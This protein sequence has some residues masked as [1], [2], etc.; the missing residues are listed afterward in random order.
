MT[1][2]H[3]HA[4]GRI[5]IG[6]VAVLL[7]VGCGAEPASGPTST[8]RD[9]AGVTIVENRGAVALDGGGW[10]LAA[11]P[12]VTIGSVDGPEEAQLYRVRGALRL[13]DGRIAV[14]NDGS[15]E[16]RMFGADGTHVRSWGRE[17]EGPG[18]FSSMI[19]TGRSGDSLVVLDR[20]LRR[21]SLVHPDAGF[22]RSFPV[23][24]AVASYPLGGW[25][26]ETGSV[27]IRDL[28]LDEA[29]VFAEGLQRAPIPFKS[30]DMSGALA[31]DFGALPGAEQ[32]NVTRQ[33][34]GGLV[35]YLASV[36]FGKSSQIAIAGDRLFVG[37]QDAFEIEMFGSDGALRRIVRLDR[38]PVPVRDADLEAYILAEVA[39]VAD[40]NEARS[41]RQDLE[42]MPRV[43]NKPAHGAIYA[44]GAGYLF[45][46]DF[47]EPG[48]EVP[49]VN[50][51][52]PEGKLVGRFDL[53]VGIQ[54][55]GI[56]ADYLLSLY[57][58]EME[59]E[60]LRLYDLIR[61]P[62]Q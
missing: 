44:D 1:V 20:R 12:N 14:A 21:V 52:D 38:D 46:E 50:V 27:L 29:T 32:I 43:E 35:T 18:E 33:A 4:I 47:R 11:R 6:P 58:D 57:R 16:I 7:V 17:G 2:K 25:F 10:S 37:G 8:V 22:V 42:Q 53:P 31:A 26:F 49:V 24:E 15:K 45:V 51:F 40:E 34:E 23:G 55:L 39:G 3:S 54:V 13:P 59:I 61:P 60:Y 30:C 9:S 36:P 62:S 28:P 41:R 48:N 19:L 56:G 5:V